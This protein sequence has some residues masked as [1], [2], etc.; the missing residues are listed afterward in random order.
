MF[1]VDVEFNVCIPSGEF[2]FCTGSSEVKL[3]YGT[4]PLE[5]AGV[6]PRCCSVTHSSGWMLADMKDWCQV[7]WVKV[8]LLLTMPTLQLVLFCQT[9]SYL[10]NRA[11][12]WES[13][14][15]KG[16]QLRLIWHYLNCLQVEKHKRLVLYSG[17]NKDFHHLLRL[18]GP[19][20]CQDMERCN[21]APSAKM[22]SSQASNESFAGHWIQN[23][24]LRLIHTCYMMWFVCLANME[25][26]FKYV[27]AGG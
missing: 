4:V 5:L 25:N 23:T 6:Q 20:L 27:K 26:M 19:G 22:S 15:I 1:H 10:S 3:S 14:T 2:S 24:Q 12:Q 21:P 7:F 13:H 9:G 17:L 16:N 11:V 18:F 8:C